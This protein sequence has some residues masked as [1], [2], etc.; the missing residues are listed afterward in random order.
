MGN[1]KPRQK[2]HVCERWFLNLDVHRRTTGHSH[3]PFTAIKQSRFVVR[4]PT[5]K[6]MSF[7]PSNSASIVQIKPG[8]TMPE[9]LRHKLVTENRSALGIAV[10]EHKGISIERHKFED[11]I[12]TTLKFLAEIDNGTKNFSRMFCFHSFPPEFDEDEIMPFVLVKDSKGGPLVCVGIEG[13]FDPKYIDTSA[14][15]FSESYKLIDTWLGP[16]VQSMYKILGNNPAKLF[17]YLRTPQF[18]NDFADQLGHRG[19]LYFLP[20]VGEMFVQEKN[21]IGVV[22]DWGGASL[23]Y[24]YTEPVTEAA[25][26]VVQ[27]VVAPKVSKSKWVTEDTPAAEPTPVVV[28]PLEAPKPATEPVEQVAADLQPEYTEL[29]PPMGLHGKP[30]K[31]W[32]RK[33]DPT[34]ELPVDWKNRPS[35]KILVKKPAKAVAQPETAISNAI[36][37]AQKQKDEKVAA[38][39][40][41]PIVSGDKLKAANEFVKRYLGDGSA[42]IKDPTEHRKM[43]AKLAV[44]HELIA[45][46]KSIDDIQQWTTAFIFAFA[47]QHPETMALAVIELRSALRDLQMNGGKTLGE[48]TGTEAPAP[49]TTVTPPATEP[50][51][52]SKVEPAPQQAVRGASR[53]A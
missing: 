14:D 26:P 10:R 32:Y 3:V 37:V 21:N 8:F 40:S 25:T 1:N 52:P 34:G 6:Q 7:K 18:S 51:T 50:S 22:G 30:L 48:L 13:D 19:C 38:I 27:E 12:P 46:M 20:N 29:F 44:F 33:N 31:A 28:P 15:G 41:M 16:K 49:G 39:T 53:W 36:T 47:Q 45:G 43:E 35:I 2:C 9:T 11:D 23:A 17:E 42:I 24:G 4:R 5:E